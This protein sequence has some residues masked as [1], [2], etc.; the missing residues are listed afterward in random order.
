MK[1]PRY[2]MGQTNVGMLEQG[3]R[4]I[5]GPQEAAAAAAAP[6]KAAAGVAGAAAG[7]AMTIFDIKNE[8]DKADDKVQNAINDGFM[9]QALDELKKEYE[10]LA[11][12]G[13]PTDNYE[14]NLEAILEARKDAL[15]SLKY[16]K[17]QQ[18]ALKVHAGNEMLLKAQ[19]QFDAPALQATKISVN[20]SVELD[21]AIK[22]KRFDDAYTLLD[23][24][25]DTTSGTPIIDPI[26]G[27]EIRLSLDEAAEKQEID[28]TVERIA[29]IYFLDK[30]EGDR[31]YREIVEN[32]TDIDKKKALTSGLESAFAD[33]DR[34]VIRQENAQELVW[35]T[36]ASNDAFGNKRGTVIMSMDDIEAKYQAGGYG[37]DK[38]ALIRRDKVMTSSLARQSVDSKYIDFTNNFGTTFMKGDETDR[39]FLD[40]RII[41]QFAARGEDRTPEDYNEILRTNIETG[42]FLPEQIIRAGKSANRSPEN[43][44]GYIPTFRMID[45]YD[46]LD[47]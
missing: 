44:K 23:I 1:I 6:Y 22:E 12:A 18:L 46:E 34:A 39:K 8:M 42:G 30:E 11:L 28:E 5:I 45:G 9:N 31:I 33:R 41:E 14:A 26:R 13:L 40:R 20:M 21:S 25:T 35:D 47:F 27:N 4:A 32:E 24:A 2:R 38:A 10:E 37:K 36:E 19:A 16:K 3:R 17:G 15:G 43:M 7:V 29:N